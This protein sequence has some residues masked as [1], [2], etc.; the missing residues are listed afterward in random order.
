M[1]LKEVIDKDRPLPA[2]DESN[3]SYPSGYASIVTSGALGSLLY[4]NSAWKN[5][6]VSTLLI[7]EAFFVCISRIYLEAHY[8]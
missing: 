6:T 5:K 8:A 4:Y 2:L 7:I 3:E 1:V